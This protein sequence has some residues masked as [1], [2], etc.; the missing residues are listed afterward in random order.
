MPNN[1]VR[2]EKNGFFPL[3]G[4]DSN[5]GPIRLGRFE[6]GTIFTC[7]HSERKLRPEATIGRI[8]NVIVSGTLAF[9]DER[10]KHFFS[11]IVEWNTKI[12]ISFFLLNAGYS[13]S[14]HRCLS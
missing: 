6:L 14:D 7:S 11:K 4:A 10:R 2:K 12:S 1:K 5:R 3:T 9:Q 8:R 13:G